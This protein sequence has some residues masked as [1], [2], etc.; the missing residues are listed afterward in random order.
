ME[1]RHESKKILH[2]ATKKLIIRGFW[3]NFAGEKSQPFVVL[4]PLAAILPP[5]GS[6]P[7]EGQKHPQ[8]VTANNHPRAVDGAQHR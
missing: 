5:R 7:Q 3:S 2:R 4:S 6:L 8:A 1:G